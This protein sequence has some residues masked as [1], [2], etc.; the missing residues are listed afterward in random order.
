[1]PTDI[2]LKCFIATS[3]ILNLPTSKLTDSP[4]HLSRSPAHAKIYSKMSTTS[5][6]DL[7]AEKIAQQFGLSSEHGQYAWRVMLNSPLDAERCQ[8]IVSSTLTARVFWV[9]VEVV[10]GRCLR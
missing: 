10:C 1:M 8:A 7:T 5:T 9:N 6:P 3:Q 2:K 4:S